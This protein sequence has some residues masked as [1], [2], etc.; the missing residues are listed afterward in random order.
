MAEQY[1]QGDVMLAPLDAVP[2]AEDAAVVKRPGKAV[3][4]AFGEVTGHSH[5]FSPA[6]REHVTMFKSEALN[7]EW[8][9]VEEEAELKHDEHGPITVAPGV[10]EVIHQREYHPEAVRRVL[11]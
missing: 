1:R 6:T 4:L 7:M 8:I 11:D 10:Y 5:Q 3:I 9:V 2:E